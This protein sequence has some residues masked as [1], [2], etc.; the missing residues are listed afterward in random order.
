MRIE[1]STHIM[2]FDG[3]SGEP[4]QVTY[5][6]RGTYRGG[7]DR[8]A[9]SIQHAVYEA[10]SWIEESLNPKVQDKAAPLET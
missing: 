3:P 1:I 8:W 7:G 2:I 4:S 5:K 9:A 6:H 10:S